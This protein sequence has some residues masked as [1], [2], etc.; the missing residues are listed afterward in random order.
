MT[1]FVWGQAAWMPGRP[2]V[3]AVLSSA[4]VSATDAGAPPLSQYPSR[5][6]RATSTLTRMCASVAAQTLENAGVSGK[7][8][9]AVFASS[10]GEVNIALDQLEMMSTGDGQISPTRFKNSVHNTSA[11]VFSVAFGNHTSSTSLAAGPLSVAYAILEAQQL[12]ADGAGQVLVVVGDES[13]PL[14]LNE[15]GA[16][17]AFA[18]GWVLGTEARPGDERPL[19]LSQVSAS[20]AAPAPVPAEL[21][22]HPCHGAYRLLDAVHHA[23]EEEVVLGA[24]LDDVLA[25]HVSREPTSGW[26][27]SL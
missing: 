5:L 1:G 18:A 9:P 3:A 26:G 11:G 2:D 15:R 13:M 17:P 10:L 27:K 25:V 21:R 12:L 20:S 23:R 6:M 14:P 8:I 19:R 24:E 16:W 22:E 7:D 4:A